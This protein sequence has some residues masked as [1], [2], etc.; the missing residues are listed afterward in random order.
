LYCCFFFFQAEDG[1]RDFHVTGVQTCALP[2][3][4]KKPVHYWK[5]DEYVFCRRVVISNVCVGDDEVFDGDTRPDIGFGPGTDRP[6][7]TGSLTNAIL[8]VID[9]DAIDNGNEP[10]NFSAADV[11]DPLAEV[12][13]RKQLRYF[14]QNVG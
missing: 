6:G 7:K 12:G 1:I 5:P 13:Q 8:L 10:N 11:N 2:I 4:K 9:E 14:S 3:S